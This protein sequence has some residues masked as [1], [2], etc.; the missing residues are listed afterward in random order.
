MII[1]VLTRN[2]FDE[3]KDIIVNGGAIAWT[4]DNVLSPK[5]IQNLRAQKIEITNFTYVISP[6]DTEAI[7][8]AISTI[9]EPHPGNSIWVEFINKQ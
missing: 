6:E 3:A 8:S 7:E 4:N 9:S 5:E 1:L 2:G